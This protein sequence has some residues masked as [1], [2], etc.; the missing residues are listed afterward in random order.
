MCGRTALNINA[1][2]VHRCTGVRTWVDPSKFRP[3]TNVAPTSFQPVIVPKTAVSVSGMGAATHDL[4]EAEAS[5]ANASQEDEEC[6]PSSTAGMTIPGS[7][8]PVPPS[9]PPSSVAP[10]FEPTST[11]ATET[12]VLFSMKWGLITGPS[13]ARGGPQP[14]NARD[15]SVIEGKP[16]F[17]GLRHRGRCVV[18]AQGFYEWIRNGTHKSAYF[19]RPADGSLMYLAG[20]FTYVDI[21]PGERVYSYTLIT[22]ENTPALSFLHDRMPVILDRASVRQWLD[23]SVTQWNSSLA[24]LLVPNDTNLVWYEVDPRVGK[25]G[26]HDQGFMTPYVETKRGEGRKMMEMWL[27][28]GGGGGG[29]KSKVQEADDSEDED[30]RKGGEV[31]DDDVIVE[32]EYDSQ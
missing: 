2:I 14:I 19:V 4:A 15:D 32:I 11:E 7:S 8:T 1:R 16:M 6:S 3:T 25:A 17:A 13:L 5:T 27:G 10:M 9:I 12:F 18:I 28:R 30:R 22:T 26:V 21:G 31:A 29:G 24:Q 20:L 23:P